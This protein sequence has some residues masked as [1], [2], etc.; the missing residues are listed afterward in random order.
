MAPSNPLVLGNGIGEDG[1]CEL[2]IKNYPPLDALVEVDEVYRG[3]SP[4][5]SG[6]GA[7]FI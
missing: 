7:A 5:V 3:G 4:K 6:N 1:K 2:S